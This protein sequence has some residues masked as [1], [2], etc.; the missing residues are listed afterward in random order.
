MGIV[1]INGNNNVRNIKILLISFEFEESVN[2]YL[3]IV[4]STCQRYKR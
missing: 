4:Y 1:Q 3:Q 2:H